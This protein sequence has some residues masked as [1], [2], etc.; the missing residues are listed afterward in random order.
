M[1]LKVIGSVLVVTAGTCIG[2]QLALRCSERPRQIRQI[3]SCLVSLKSYINYA[4]LPL[5]EALVRCASSAEGVVADLFH[6]TAAILQQ[7]GWLTPQ[8]ALTQAL[9]DLRAR[10]V[11]DKP[12]LEALASLGANLG[13]TN[14]EEQEKYL[15]LVQDELQ[16]IER[17]AIQIRERNTKMYRYL[18][19]CGGLALVILLV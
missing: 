1:W 12:E 6:Q 2:F 15:L 5:P 17:D 10:L 13:F 16:T 8:E 14:R 18:G 7:K 19:V 9:G 11:L 3:I 4:A